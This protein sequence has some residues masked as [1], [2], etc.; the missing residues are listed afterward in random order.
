MRTE[1]RLTIGHVSLDYAKNDMGFD[2][3]LLFQ[4]GDLTRCRSDRHQL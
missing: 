1:I 2:Y 4:D 3:G